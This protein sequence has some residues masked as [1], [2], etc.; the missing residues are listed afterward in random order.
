M[1]LRQKAKCLK[2]VLLVTTLAISCTPNVPLPP[3]VWEKLWHCESLTLTLYEPSVLSDDELWSG[4]GLIVLKDHEKPIVTSFGIEGLNRRWDWNHGYDKEE[5]EQKGAYRYSIILDDR[6]I[7][8]Y[9]DFKLEE[10]TTN[11][12]TFS[13]HR[14]YFGSM[15]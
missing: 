7:A 5:F 3:G 8:R 15:F 1:N 4:V 10:R 13:C 2:I 12:K 6:G 9:Y 14:H 11:E